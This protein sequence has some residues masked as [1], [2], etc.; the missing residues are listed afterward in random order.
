MVPPASR[1]ELAQWLQQPF[2][3]HADA[4]SDEQLNTLRERIE[5]LVNY[6][7][8]VGL[9][10]KSGAGKSSLCNALFGQEVAEV[11]DVA[12][13]TTGASEYTLA[14][15]N[16]KGIS[17]IDLPGVGERQD[18][19]AAYAKQYQDMLPELDLV[20][21]LIKA[22][23]R[24]LSVDE[25]CYQRLILP[26]LIEHDIPLL[27]V[28]N[29]VD[30]I[31]PCREWDF[32]HSMPGP[33]QLTNISRKQLQISQLFNVPLTQIFVTSAVEGYGLQILIEQIIHK[34][35]KEKKWSVTRET[36][37]EY[38]TP[39]MQRE[40]IAGLWD[41]IKEA[42]KTILRETWTTISYR[43]ESWFS[44]LFGW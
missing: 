10:G 24:A 18:K 36:R 25:Q 12:P 29:Q 32:I 41:T 26:Y 37:A 34:L 5:E 38:V 2:Q 23:D 6:E 33:Q 22:D 17:L 31:E 3:S 20:L 16:G 40:S 27:F 7:A 39:A 1:Q 14:Y 13:C 8:A 9:M 44:K 19:E 21:W 15:Q 43:V 4:F 35:P 30:K 28:V 42:A 11:D